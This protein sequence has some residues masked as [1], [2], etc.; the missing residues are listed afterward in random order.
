MSDASMMPLLFA[1]TYLSIWMVSPVFSPV[2]CSVMKPV[3]WLLIA[4][5]VTLKVTARAGRSKAST[6]STRMRRAAK[7][8]RK[9]GSFFMMMVNAHRLRKHQ[10]DERTGKQQELGISEYPATLHGQAESPPGRF[11]QPGGL[12][13][14]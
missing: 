4:A 7:P 11:F 6:P 9:L 5:G 14:E 10:P 2:I 3:Y 12:W 13:N 8:L 1:S